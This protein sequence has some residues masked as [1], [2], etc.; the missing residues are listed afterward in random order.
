MCPLDLQR[1]WEKKYE[2]FNLANEE[3]FWIQLI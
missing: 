3:D 2:Q 1:Q